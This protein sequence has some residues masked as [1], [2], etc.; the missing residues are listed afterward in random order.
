MSI[1]DTVSERF[2]K[3]GE[4]YA[5]GF[6]ENPEQPL[7]MRFARALRRFYENC[8][9]K[10]YGKEPLY[11]SGSKP[12]GCLVRPSFSYTVDVDW[13]GLNAADSELAE[14]LKKDLGVYSS[15]V[16]TE[17]TVGGN[18]YTHSYPNFRRIM[19][20][21]F[22]SYEARVRQIA[23]ESIRTGL[24]DLLCG[25]RGY[26]SR[27]LRLIEKEAPDSKL[28]RALC[29][30]PF[31]PT[32]TLY[33]AIVCW[34]FVYYL[35]GCDN[36]GLPDADLIRFYRGEDV[37]ELLRCFFK[38]VDANNGWSGALGSEYN[39]ITLQCLKAIKGLRRPSIELR[40]A[41]DMPNELW[42]AAID[43]IRAGGGSPSLY[44][45][46]GYTDALERAF[47]NIPKADISRFAG[48]GCTETMLAG[49]SNVGS[50]D[51][52][53][54][55][56][57]IFERFMRSYLTSS[58]T[59]E[60][61]YCSFIQQYR[62]EA[63]KVFEAISKSQELR[64]AYR[65]HPMR[66]LLIDD[67]IEKGKDYNGGG[68]RYYWS[69]VNLAG[70]INVIDSLTVIDRLVFTDKLFSAEAFLKRLD[71][72]EDFLSYTNAPRHGADNDEAN[73][74][75]RRLSAD[76]VSPFRDAKPYLGGAFLPSSIQFITY[77]DAGKGV[78][79]TPDGRAA[80][81]PLCD[82]I[83]AIHGNDKYGIT[84]L[85]NSAASICQ[86][87]MCGTPVL[88]VMLDS[89]RM[90]KS[91]RALVLGYFENGGMQLQITCVNREELL[92]AKERPD[93]YPNLI[94]RIGGYSEYF[95]RLSPEL[96]QTVIERTEYEA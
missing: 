62:S 25:I 4:F 68:A 61:F 20:E 13:S 60:E 95:N 72:G 83:G 10:P 1:N 66:T 74:M 36:I 52:G 88:N 85:L 71:E 70:M 89:T 86:K 23:D 32:E 39:E 57:L 31:K 64:A 3:I 7:F 67:C 12:G 26:H 5:A 38:N 18:M 6:Y 59:F 43:S 2:K 63:L 42:E 44:N 29:K 17:H 78:G 35:D 48:G 46:N 55:V 9:L 50:L 11:P 15:A 53:I 75:A 81:S 49:M 14:I 28:Y 76:L 65:P 16:P 73:E 91:L 21:G 34:N 90:S 8:Q 80:G 19:A 40:V 79:A 37:T 22:D 96:Q 51:A 45:E 87:D 24:L 77:A 54:N 41:P 94:V 56:A 30:V 58:G 69:V 93:Q 92:R 33:E 27:I 82:S 84:A 47:P